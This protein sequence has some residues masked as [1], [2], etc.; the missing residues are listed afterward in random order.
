M[1]DSE[2]AAWSTLRDLLDNKITAEGLI[3]DFGKAE[4]AAVHF[5]FKGKGFHQSVTASVMKGL[6]EYQ[7]AFNR[8]VA[9]I[10][11]EDARATRLTLDQR[12]ELEF[13]F[14]VSEGSSDF[15]ADA[16]EQL[17]TLGN[18]AVDKMSGKEIAIALVVCSLVFCGHYTFNNFIDRQY[19]ETKQSQ[20]IDKERN[21]KKDLYEFLLKERT[22]QDAN[23]KTLDEA[24]ATSEQARK[25]ATM[26]SKAVDE[27][28]RSNSGADQITIQ[29][30]IID[31]EL[32]TSLVKGT[33][34]T[35]KPIVIE[36]LFTVDAVIS[37]DVE[38][39]TVRLKRVSNGELITAS[40]ADP[41]IGSSAQRAIS[42]AQWQASEI[43]VQL[44]A[45]KV[46]DQ[47]RDASILKAYKPRSH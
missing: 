14:A 22:A 35:A 25:V 43:K 13:V 8:A 17:K 7:N 41:L 9:L 40:L 27:I 18:K 20:E 39:F 47:L 2:E 24:M 19:E 28:I 33:R 26:N 44:S 46:G 32:I 12:S 21:E 29:G 5:N 36:D 34:N 16:F 11:T 4:W 37:D 1:I 42:R 10:W 3:L 30:E 38:S 45:R 31:N 15:F 6:V 23:R